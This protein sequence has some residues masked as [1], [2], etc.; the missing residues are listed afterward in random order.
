[1]HYNLK[2]NPRSSVLNCKHRFID[3]MNFSHIQSEMKF[4]GVLAFHFLMDKDYIKFFM[5]W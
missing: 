4:F 3:F 2:I 1:M 5:R